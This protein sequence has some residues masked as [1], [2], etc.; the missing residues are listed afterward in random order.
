VEYIHEMHKVKTKLA[1]QNKIDE[2]NVKNNFIFTLQDIKSFFFH[3]AHFL[4]S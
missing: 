4:F 2:M 3:N 1:S